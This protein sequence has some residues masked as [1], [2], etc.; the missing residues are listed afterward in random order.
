MAA[1]KV[2][3]IRAPKDQ[4]ETLGMTQA[5]AA[6]EAGVICTT[7]R[8]WEDVGDNNHPLLAAILAEHHPCSW[9]DP[10]DGSGARLASAAHEP[11]GRRLTAI[12]LRV[13]QIVLCPPAANVDL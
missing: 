9:F 3:D 11:G 7:W 1:Q 8:R 2:D 6:A 5:E 13:R 12:V 4:R 10:G